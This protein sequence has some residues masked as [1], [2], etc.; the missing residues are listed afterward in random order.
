MREAACLAGEPGVPEWL[1]A[2]AYPHRLSDAQACRMWRRAVTK[3]FSAFSGHLQ[4]EEGPPRPMSGA[5]VAITSAH[6]E[7]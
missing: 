6:W 1:M 7:H 5:L 2:Y 4:E 3:P